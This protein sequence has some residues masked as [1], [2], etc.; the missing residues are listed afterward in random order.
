MPHTLTMKEAKEKMDK[1][2]EALRQELGNLRTGRANAGMLDTIDIEVYGTKMK[3]NQLGT[4]TVPDPHTIAVDLWDKSQIAVVEKAL[5]ASPLDIN[6]TN[7]GRLI[8]VPIPPLSEERRKD[9][10]KYAGKLTEEAKVAVRNIRRHAVE[11]I[12][13]LQKEGKIPE[14]DA[15]RLTED[16]QKMTDD[17]IAAMDEALKIK[18]ADIMEV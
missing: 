8:R 18:E 6:P 16:V 13:A 5:R 17:H 11:S 10:V 7:D 12:K 14:D 4:V 15:H 2:L 3:I 9:I 1:S